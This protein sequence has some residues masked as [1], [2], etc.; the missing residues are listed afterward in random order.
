MGIRVLGVFKVIFVGDE[1]RCV[2]LIVLVDV[3]VVLV[4]EMDDDE[5]E[6]AVD[7]LGMVLVV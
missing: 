1:E 2:L 4:A 5:L 7:E 3:L 6:A